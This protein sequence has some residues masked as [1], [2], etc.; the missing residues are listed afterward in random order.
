MSWNSKV[1]GHRLNNLLWLLTV[2][3]TAHLNYKQGSKCTKLYLHSTE[4]L[5]GILVT[6]KGNKGSLNW[7]K[8]IT[9][10]HYFIWQITSLFTRI[11]HTMA[12]SA[13]FVVI[14]LCHALGLAFQFSVLQLILGFN[15]PYSK[16]VLEMIS[17]GLPDV[18]YLT[19]TF[20]VLCSLKVTWSNRSD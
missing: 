3:L 6:H 8:W 10:G 9:Q 19:N 5:Y 7:T 11:I 12:G 20:T 16:K 14:P 15:S 18:S 17:L 4:C 13:V 1:I 2:R